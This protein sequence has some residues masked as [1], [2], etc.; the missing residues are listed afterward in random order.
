MADMRW[1]YP[2]LKGRCCGLCKHSYLND[3]AVGCRLGCKKG[4]AGQSF[5]LPCDGT[6]CK[7]FE[8]NPNE[9]EAVP[10]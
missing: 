7:D 4:H 1:L 2:S 10:A 9:R 6:K 8:P 3:S 5:V